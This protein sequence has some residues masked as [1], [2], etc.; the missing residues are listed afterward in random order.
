MQCFL[1]VS[2]KHAQLSYCSPLYVPLFCLTHLDHFPLFS[3]P[4]D[5]DEFVRTRVHELEDFECNLAALRQRRRD[6]ERLPDQRRVDCFVLSL[7]PFKA[8]VDD[9]IQVC[10][11]ATM[12]CGHIV[13]RYLIFIQ[14]Q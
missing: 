13:N 6:A 10:A 3:R 9:Q 12:N 2:S 4:V 7:V 11:L 1:N 8:A 5:V 14:C